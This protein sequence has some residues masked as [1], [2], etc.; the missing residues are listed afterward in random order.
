MNQ[1]MIHNLPTTVTHETPINKIKP[2][3]LHIITSEYLIPSYGPSKK[4]NLPRGL[5]SLNT[6]P[7]KS[8]R[9]RRAL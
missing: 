3:I 6:F 1:Q 8:D 4:R 9:A 7:R 2:L 5:Q